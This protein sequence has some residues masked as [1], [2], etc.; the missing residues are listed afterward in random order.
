MED[1]TVELC[2]VQR[3]LQ[4]W[5]GRAEEEGGGASL[6]CMPLPL[7]RPPQKHSFPLSLSFSH[8]PFCPCVFLHALSGSLSL[9]SSLPFCPMPNSPFLAHSLPG[10]L[11]PS[12][13]VLIWTRFASTKARYWRPRYVSLCYSLSLCFSLFPDVP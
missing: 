7:L 8:C 11:L 6:L 3:R 4:P 2:E 9:S 13:F 12:P 10:C 1:P 5:M